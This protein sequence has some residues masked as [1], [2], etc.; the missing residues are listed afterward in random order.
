[1]LQWPTRVIASHFSNE[2][3]LNS[4]QEENQLEVG[5]NGIV[6]DFRNAGRKHRWLHANK[7]CY[8]SLG[9]DRL[10][11]TVSLQHVA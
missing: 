8:Y 11:L 10:V 1:M 4:H 7:I 5:I 6:S 9:N 2:S 3:T